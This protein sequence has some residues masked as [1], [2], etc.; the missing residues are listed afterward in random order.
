MKAKSKPKGYKAKQH[1]SDA[2][3]KCSI[4][5]SFGDVNSQNLD[6]NDARWRE[7]PDDIKEGFKQARRWWKANW[8]VGQVI[9]LRTA[10]FNH[11]F[12][13]VPREPSKKN[14]AK[15]KQWQEDG[16]GV[17]DNTWPAVMRYVGEAVRE[18]QLMDNLITFWRTKELPFLLPAEKV[19]YSDAMGVEKLWA[20]LGHTQKDLEGGEFDDKE[21]KR[22]ST[23]NI[24]LKDPK[25]PGAE[26]EE[27]YLVTTRQLRGEGLGWP[28]LY[29]VFRTL[30]QN[31]SM[32]VG[33][34]QY[35]MMGRMVVEQHKIGFEARSSALA[36]KQ[37]NFLW[38]KERSDDILKLFNGAMGHLR[39]V[40]QFDHKIEHVWIDPAKYDGDK[41]E[42][43]VNRLMWW[44]GPLAWMMMAKAA[45]PYLLDMLGKQMIHERRFYVGPHLNRVLAA[46]GGLPCPCRVKWCE[47]IFR[48]PRLAWDQIK[49]LTTQGPLSLTSALQSAGRNPETEGE[50]KEVEAG[51]NRARFLPIFDASH[52]KRPGEPGKPPGTKT[53]EGQN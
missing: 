8:F 29:R 23:K 31:E 25:V 53:G 37:A 42:T 44:G 46:C 24:L 43:I 16:E 20:S 6:I 1:R 33:E 49:F 10:F 4:D 26:E 41:W 40:T 28:E 11:G 32:E 52:G 47:D 7:A 3:A 18:W 30:S 36:H 27:N 51:A 39:T 9:N 35:A 45:S 22:Y 21:I 17:K 48:D 15:L 12:E 5:F 14:L 19:K 2:T 13:L 34:A 50:L 38:D